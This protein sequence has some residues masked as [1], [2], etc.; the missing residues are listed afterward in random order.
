MQP[1]TFAAV[2]ERLQQFERKLS[3]RTPAPLGC[4]WFNLVA[5]T[6]PV[7]VSAPHA[8]M[9]QRDGAAKMEEEYTGAIAQLLSATTGCH[10]IFSAH[11]SP[12]DPNWHFH[13]DYKSGV[14]SLHKRVGLQLVID[15][16]G[17]LNQHRM[18]IAIGSIN[19]L[20]CKAKRVVP[21][22]EEQGFLGCDVHSLTED[23]DSDH[24]RRLVVDHPRFTGGV[25]N[26]TMTRFVSETLGIPAVQVELAS[27]AR[28]VNSPATPDWP[29]AYRGNITAIEASVRALQSL[30]LAHQSVC[31]NAG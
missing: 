10:A 31:M 16:H 25:R 20:S 3:Y 22:F 27:V 19:G 24:W 13:S 17:M 23:N 26:H 14:A 7:L 11:R 30:V 2:S 12:E 9:H 1:H 28:V 5:G 29:V 21:F 4:S 15:L 8:C 18:G 6:I